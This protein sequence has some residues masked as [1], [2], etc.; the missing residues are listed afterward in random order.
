MGV[1]SVLWSPV[2]TLR[3]AAEQRNVLAGFIVVAALAAIGTVGNTIS[4]M[5]SAGE[6]INPENF[7]QLPPEFV[8]G[9]SSGPVTTVF[10]LLSAVI[11]P[12][13][14]WALISLI[15]QLVTRF[16][17]GEGPLS[18]MFA[19]VG[20]AQIPY[21]VSALIGLPITVLV[22]VIGPTGTAAVVLTSISSLIGLLAFI[23]SVVLVIIGAAQS[24]NISYGESTGSCAISCAGCFV[25]L[26][27]LG[28]VVAIVISVLA[29]AGS[30]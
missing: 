24:R 5:T 9:A 26:F 20:I 30:Q 2:Q 28:I 1:I 10:T 6:V 11:S 22:A 4:L 25:L 12:F 3:D 16:F 7:P 8:E 13:I 21:V 18:A 19:V 29:G 15:L 14:T 23:W 17:G 27:G